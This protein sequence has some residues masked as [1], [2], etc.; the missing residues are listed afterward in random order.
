M[1]SYLTTL[2]RQSQFM[3]IRKIVLTAGGYQAEE[4]FEEQRPKFG[5]PLFDWAVVVRTSRPFNTESG[6]TDGF[7]FQFLDGTSSSQG[8][9]VALVAHSISFNTTDPS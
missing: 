2:A 7:A 8:Q 6:V 3:V 5:G 4:L 1:T 9:A